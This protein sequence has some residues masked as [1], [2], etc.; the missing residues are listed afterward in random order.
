MSLPRM[1]GVSLFRALPAGAAGGRGNDGG[2]G[3]FL[4]PAK[5]SKMVRFLD[6]LRTQLE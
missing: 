1:K 6:G 4:G 5:R 2:E 3:G